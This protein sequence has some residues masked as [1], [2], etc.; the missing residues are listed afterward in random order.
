[1]GTAYILGISQVR[2]TCTLMGESL[3]QGQSDG[4]EISKPSGTLPIGGLHAVLGA[5]QLQDLGL[6]TQELGHVFLPGGRPPWL[7][8]LRARL[9]AL[10]ARARVF[11][12]APLPGTPTVPRP[13]A[14]G[15]A[16]SQPPVQLVLLHLEAR[17][18]EGRET[19][20]GGVPRI[21]Q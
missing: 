12:V 16:L 21:Q 17:V 8:G 11:A 20:E 13:Q 1:M 2:I 6:L 7:A 3:E 19:S 5:Q 15:G 14:L 10:A 9:A 4:W 18:G